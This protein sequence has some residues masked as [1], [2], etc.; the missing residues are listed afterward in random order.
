MVGHKRLSMT[1]V[2]VTLV[3]LQD[4]KFQRPLQRRKVVK[5]H[6]L[7]YSNIFEDLISYPET[8]EI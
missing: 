1:W 3:W 6:I 7:V 4:E 2:Q 8:I 5:Q